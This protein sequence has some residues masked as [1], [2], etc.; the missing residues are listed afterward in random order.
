MRG[1]VTIFIDGQ[2]DSCRCQASLLT[3]LDRGRGRVIVRDA[4]HADP[5]AM[6]CA[7]GEALRQVHALLPDGRIVAGME[8]LRRAYAAL[9]WGW[10]LAPTGWPVLRPLF[11]RLY[12]LFAR[13]R[14]R[15]SRP[16]REG[17]PPPN[18]S[19]SRSGHTR[20]S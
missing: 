9:G 4:R 20:R 19:V 18:G 15:F 13:H 8:A 14:M 17:V 11:D 1:P 12:A 10:L 5:A 6:V 2:C 3:R 16:S 7:P